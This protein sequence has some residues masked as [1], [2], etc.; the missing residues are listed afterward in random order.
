MTS[1]QKTFDSAYDQVL[2]TGSSSDENAIASTKRTV[3][4]AQNDLDQHLLRLRGYVDDSFNEI[5]YPWWGKMILVF[6]H[7][8]NGEHDFGSVT[9]N[10]LKPLRDEL[11]RWVQALGH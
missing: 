7:I 9:K 8:E 6:N 2:L 10:P 5:L 4:C 3:S 1:I 11:M